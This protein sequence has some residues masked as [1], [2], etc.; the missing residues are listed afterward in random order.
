[1]LYTN[2][3]WRFRGFRYKV[4]YDNGIREIRNKRYIEVV[5]N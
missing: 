4:Y 1:M 5:V 2:G 3:K